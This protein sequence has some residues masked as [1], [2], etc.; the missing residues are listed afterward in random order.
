MQG[1][2][3]QKSAYTSHLRTLVPKAIPGMVFGTRVLKW[4]IDGPF[5]SETREDLSRSTHSQPFE[6]S[7]E[8][9]FI[10][11]ASTPIQECR[12]AFLI[13]IFRGCNLPRVCY[14]LSNRALTIQ[15]LHLFLLFCSI[16]YEYEEP[17]F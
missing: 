6:T 15:L 8:L 1:H 9:S 16:K 7:W 5:G 4:A 14:A 11:H 10:L 2:V 3:T 12:I 17:A 13:K